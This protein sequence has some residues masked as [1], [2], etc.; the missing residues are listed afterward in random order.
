MG[1]HL[2]TTDDA[3]IQRSAT[4]Y[5]RVHRKPHGGPKTDWVLSTKYTDSE[6][7][8]L[9]YGYRY[10]QSESGRWASRDPLGGV[11]GRKLHGFVLNNPLCRN[12]AV[13]L[14]YGNPYP[15]PGPIPIPVPNLPPPTGKCR[16]TLEC[17]P[18]A[19]SPWKHCFIKCEKS[20]G[21]M[22]VCRGGPGR[23]SSC[24][25]CGVL[26]SV[27]TRCDDYAQSPDYNEPPMPGTTST[28][29]GDYDCR[30]CKCIELQTKW[31]EYQCFN[32]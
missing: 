30:K 5:T 29:L 25:C 13:G 21:T 32:Y 7:G 27:V 23:S 18:V 6:T 24:G 31:V 2:T 28:V 4:K 8:L 10:Y 26:G 19:G 1:Y 9:F 20:D 14:V 16:I 11:G 15:D 12:D 22:R 17:R 3:R